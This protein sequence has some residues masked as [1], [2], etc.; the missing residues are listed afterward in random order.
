MMMWGAMCYKGVRKLVFVDGRM[1]SEQYESVLG[2]G[3]KMTID[4]HDIDR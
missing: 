3:Y 2:L 1:D 4:M